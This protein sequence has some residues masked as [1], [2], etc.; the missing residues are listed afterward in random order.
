MPELWTVAPVYNEEKNLQA[1]VEEWLSVFREVTGGNFTFCLLND[2]STDG[3]LAILNKLASRNPELRVIDKTNSG[4]GPTCLLGYGLAIR[5]GAQWI[6]QI[7]SDGQCDPQQFR[8]FWESRG[9]GPAHYGCRKAREDGWIRRLISKFLSL[10]ILIVSFR[11]VKDANVPYRLMS[12]EALGDA[13]LRIPP[14]FRLSNALL[15]IIQ[16]DYPGIRWHDIPFRKRSGRQLPLKP[17]FFLREGKQF[18]TDYVSWIWNSKGTGFSGKACV[19]GK[20]LLALFS[21]Y[22]LVAFLILGLIMTFDPWEYNWIEGGHLTQV[23]RILESQALYPAPSL[24]YVP[25]LYCPLYM[26]V[27]S[28]FALIFGESYASLR[29]VSFAA[30]IGTQILLGAI[31]WK[32]T[33]NGFA[34]FLAAGLY[35]G[36]YGVVHWH[37]TLARLDSLYVFLTLVFVCAFWNASTR[38]GARMLIAAFA[39]AAAVFTKQPALICVLALCF[40]GFFHNARARLTSVLCIAAVGIG[41][42]IPLFTGNDW[43]FY[44]LY[45]MPSAHPVSLQSLLSFLYRDMFLS[46]GFGLVASLFAFHFLHKGKTDKRQVWY[47]LLFFAA[48]AVAGILPRIK[49]GGDVNNLMPIAATIALCC[50]FVAGSFPAAAGWRKPGFVLLLLCF[51]F[52]ILY[53]PL[54]GFP[55]AANRERM[56][57]M[58]EVFE[59]L[60]TPIFAPVHPHI[61]LA[62]GKNQSAFWGAMYDILIVR[63]EPAMRLREELRLA[64]REKRFRTIVLKK[65]FFGQ[66]KF[67]Y[68]ELEGSYK[69]QSLGYDNMVIYAPIE[70]VR[71]WE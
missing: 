63:G 3:S 8:S 67:P 55:S 27:S 70:P 12:R 65:R 59:H 46:L 39:S 38:G 29:I 47:F 48:M 62:A 45:A 24:E 43:F 34:A 49:I 58:T 66:D 64:L 23:H 14:N 50:G 53:N 4:H 60:E 41:S 9:D 71:Q 52:Q 69:I 51:N 35:A 10:V 17:V 28:F 26:Y 44:Y 30:S 25:L 22:F 33:R 18:V 16:N 37:Y 56:Q 11:W 5:S 15:T 21:A 42:A 31:I 19:A 20:A 13:L 54:K 7:D 32:K 1:F 2:G 6:F 61:P 36:M 40:W 57:R 68:A